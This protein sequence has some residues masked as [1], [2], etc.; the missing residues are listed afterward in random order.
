MINGYGLNGYGTEALKTFAD[1]LHC[2][3]K[4]NEIVFI[5]VLSAC[6]HCGLEYEGW[7]WFYSMEEKYGVPPKLAHYACMVDLLSRQGN[8][9]EALEFVN[10]MPVEPDK[11]IWGALLAGCRLTPGSIEIAE[12][13]ADRL[14]GLDPQNTSYY[15]ILSNL[16]AD[17][18]RWGDVE[19]LR[20]LLDERGLRK[21]VGCSMIEAN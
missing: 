5:S 10:K 9:E 1:M 6:S 16:Y 14:V 21:T 11:R 20:K 12:L 3:I 15:V 13:V 18:G 8:I 4:P 19:R 7:S 2:G 17:Q